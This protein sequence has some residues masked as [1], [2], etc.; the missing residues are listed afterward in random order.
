MQYFKILS[1]SPKDVS[2]REPA[3]YFIFSLMLSRAADVICC[4]PAFVIIKVFCILFNHEKFFASS[5]ENIHSSGTL[6]WFK[7]L[8][9]SDT[10]IFLMTAMK[11]VCAM[12]NII[13]S[14]AVNTTI[15][16]G[17]DFQGLSQ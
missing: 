15:Y 17:G 12:Q 14:S 16:Y 8:H 1:L 2:R 6:V 13:G 7:A 11:E 5:L 9:S 4:V 10:G 3:S